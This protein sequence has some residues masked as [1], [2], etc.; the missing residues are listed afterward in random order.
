MS[1]HAHAHAHATTPRGSAAGPASLRYPCRAPPLPCGL[2]PEPEKTDNDEMILW[3]VG[4]AAAV[5][6]AAGIVIML[7]KR[8][9]ARGK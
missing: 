6:G 1:I 5:F 7:L 8:R 3:I 4:G 2:Q 9:A